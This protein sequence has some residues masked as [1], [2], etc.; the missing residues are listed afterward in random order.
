MMMMMIV[1]MTME[2]DDIAAQ[3]Q[4]INGC[5]K[6][7]KNWSMCSTKYVNSRKPNV[8]KDGVEKFRYIFFKL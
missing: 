4:Q 6:K 2:Y 8:E 1:V 7:Y 5:Y 3:I